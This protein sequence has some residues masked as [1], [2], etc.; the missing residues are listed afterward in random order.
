MRTFADDEVQCYE[1]KI[2]RLRR[3]LWKRL[4][5]VLP[6]PVVRTYQDNVDCDRDAVP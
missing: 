3:K 1:C 5:H 4:S 2:L 6:Y